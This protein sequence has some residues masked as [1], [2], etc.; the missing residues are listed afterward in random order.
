MCILQCA[1]VNVRPN[2]LVIGLARYQRMPVVGM[3]GRAHRHSKRHTCGA[4]ACPGGNHKSTVRQGYPHSKHPSLPGSPLLREASRRAN[5]LGKGSRGVGW[6][7]YTALRRR[8]ER[9]RCQWRPGNKHSGHGYQGRE[10]RVLMSCYEVRGQFSFCT[11]RQNT[12]LAHLLC[13][14]SSVATQLAE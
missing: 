6:W 1:C 7:R 9:R 14:L 5:L 12:C 4:P 10:V 8:G 13:S 11:T 3:R 2:S